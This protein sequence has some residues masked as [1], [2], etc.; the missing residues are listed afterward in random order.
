MRTQSALSDKAWKRTIDSLV[1]N[2]ARERRHTLK[3][4]R[5]H[6]RARGLTGQTGE[7]ND[8]I[9]RRAGNGV[10]EGPRRSRWRREE[11]RRNG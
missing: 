5:T 11:H 6:G 1:R 2:G 3:D 7:G 8:E 10:E 9:G 4:C